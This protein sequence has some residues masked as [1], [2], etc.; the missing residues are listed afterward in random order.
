MKLLILLII[1]IFAVRY[2]LLPGFIPTHDG[3]YHIIRF[4]Q[5]ENEIRAGD[6]FPIWAPDLN[7]GYGL[8]LFYY[9]YPMPNYFGV[10]FHQFGFSYTDSFKLV[11]ATFYIL[12][13][14]FFY[15]WSRSFWGTI[16]FAW[17]PYWFVNLFVRGSIGE[18][19]ASAGFAFVLW[20]NASRRNILISLGVAFIILSHNIAAMLFVPIV[21]LL[22]FRSTIVGILLA[23]YFWLPAI[24]SR[25]FVLGLTSVN[26]YDHFSEISQLLIPSW[27]TGFSQPGAPYNE[28]SQQLGLGSILVGFATIPRSFILVLIA[29]MTTAGSR[30]IW[31]TL[32]FLQLVQYPWRI[33]MLVPFVVGYLA[34]KMSGR[35]AMIVAAISVL[36]A[37]PYT[38][39]VVYEPRDDQYYLSRREF[40]DGTSSLGNSMST[41]WSPWKQER[42]KE[43]IEIVSGEGKLEMHELLPTRLSFAVNAST[44]VTVRINT[45]YFPG[46]EIQQRGHWSPLVPDQNG[47]MSVELSAGTSQIRVELHNT[48]LRK[49]ALIV[50][51][52]SFIWVLGSGIL[53]R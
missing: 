7:S 27:G 43:K 51:L 25:D 3:E 6:Y 5:F 4:W 1:S 32:P 30:F 34:R 44:P 2:L 41:V 47:L 20:T 16:L 12:A 21:L 13:V 53:K 26:L 17:T 45:V 40:T 28:M 29:F 39:P 35:F 18:V 24:F 36:A 11:L 22:N 33:L 10:L 42:T 15:L 8:P 46:W 14:L 19:M 38:K 50:S 23:A 37:L 49:G 9:H 48:A 52:I 31:N